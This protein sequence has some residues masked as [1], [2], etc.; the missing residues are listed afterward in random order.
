MPFQHQI[1]AIMHHQGWDHAPP[2]S[3][4]RSYRD[5]F[6][7]IWARVPVPGPVTPPTHPVPDPEPPQ[8]V[9]DDDEEEMN[10]LNKDAFWWPY[11]FA[12]L[13]L[14]S[15]QGLLLPHATPRLGPRWAR[16]RRRSLWPSRSSGW[17]IPIGRFLPQHGF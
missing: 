10:A 11:C 4:R 6:H 2:H 1:Q 8:H 16:W 13:M 15:C 3:T 14:L 17:T 12:A 5:A 7:A 9:L